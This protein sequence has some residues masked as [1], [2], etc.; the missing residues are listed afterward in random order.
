MSSRAKYIT[1]VE[2]DGIIGYITGDKNNRRYNTKLLIPPVLEETSQYYDS[3]YECMG[4]WYMSEEFKEWIR[5]EAE[6]W[7][8]EINAEVKPGEILDIPSYPIPE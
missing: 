7:A 1:L 4:D 8:E 2:R 5:D 3:S 6:E